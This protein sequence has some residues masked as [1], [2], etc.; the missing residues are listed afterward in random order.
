MPVLFEGDLHVHYGQF[1]VESQPG[2]NITGQV[3]GGQVNGLCGAA[4]PGTLFLITG[5]HTGEVH[6][7]VELHDEQVPVTDEWEE[8]VEVSFR[9]ETESVHLVQWAGEA[10]WPLPLPQVDYRVRYCASGMDA[11]S[12]QD[13][14]LDDEPR[15]DRYLL[16]FWPGP[17]APDVVVRETSESAAYWNAHAK[18]LPPPPTPQERAEAELRERLAREQAT[19]DAVHAAEVRRWGGRLPSE[20]VRAVNGSLTM[21]QLDSDLVAAIEDLDADTQRALGRWSAR[22]ACVAAHLA[23]VDW[24]ARALTALDHDLPLPQPFDDHNAAFDLLIADPNAPH[25]TTTS[26]D[27]QRDNLSQQHMALPAVW[28]AAASDPL[29]AGLES[30]FHAMVAYGADY[31]A[32][33][34]EVRQEFPRLR[35]A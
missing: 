13:S 17:P 16:Q 25:T 23:E 1:Y 3:R 8:V 26:L 31:P 30:L 6:L 14:R 20:R 7:T 19:K 10:S 12:D 24:V 21:V 5:L 32:L 2:L 9:P 18:T 29:A 34:A 27:G 4:E 35:T 28:S 22:R 11:A 33:L 15:F